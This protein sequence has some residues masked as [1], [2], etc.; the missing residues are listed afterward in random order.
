MSG[1]PNSTAMNW[2]ET[3]LGGD[4][5]AEDEMI[6][7]WSREIK[8]IQK[9][10]QSKNN[11]PSPRRGFHAKQHVGVQNAEFVVLDHLP[12]FLQVGIFQPGARYQAIV[13]LSNASGATQSDHKGDLRGVAVRVQVDSETDIDLL[14]TNG[15]V[16]FA[17]DPGQFMAFA[18]ATTGSRL[19]M[20]PSLI[21]S[22][23]VSETIR[24]LRTAIKDSRRTV[25]SLSTEQFWSRGAYRFGDFA[26]RFTFVPMADSA[27]EPDKDDPDYLR[28]EFVGRLATEPVSWN[29]MVQLF[30]DEEKTPIED[31]ATRWSSEFVNIARLT[32]P[33]Q[34]LTAPGHGDVE[35]SVDSLEF[36]PWTTTE[37]FRPLGSINRARRRVYDASQAT[38][39]T[40]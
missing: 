20:L 3:Y 35:D 6:D 2:R 13:R 16:S 40:Q 38:R 39:K 7:A 26:V 4:E 25:L 36:N 18:K 19:M 33:Q 10:I 12:D 9:A 30:F 5:H 1:N 34:D 14:A 23:G 29:Y 37:E 27:P 17:R 32:I 8:E 28:H 24:M 15:A 21:G 11:A 22:V 31:A